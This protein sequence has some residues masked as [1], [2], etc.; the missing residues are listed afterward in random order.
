MAVIWDTS[1]TPITVAKLLTPPP[2]SPSR[3]ASFY[4]INISDLRRNDNLIIDYPDV[5]NTFFRQIPRLYKMTT[6]EIAVLQFLCCYI[7]QFLRFADEYG[8]YPLKRRCCITT[9]NK[10]IPKLVSKRKLDISL[11]YNLSNKLE[12]NTRRFVLGF[13][14]YRSIIRAIGSTPFNTNKGEEELGFNPTIIEDNGRHT[15][16]WRNSSLRDQS[17]QGLVIKD[18]WEYKERPKEGLLL[19]EAIEAGIKNIARYYYYETM[20]IGGEVD[21]VLDNVRKEL[22]NTVSMPPPKRLCL[23]SLVKKSIYKASSLYGILIGLL[24]GINDISIGNIMLNMAEDDGFLIDLNRENASG[25]PSKTG[26]KVFIVIGALYGDEDYNFIYDLEYRTEYKSWNYK[27]IRELA[28]VKAGKVLKQ[29]KFDK[30]VD[31]NFTAHCKVLIPYIRE[32]C[33]VVFLG[34]KRWIIKD[35]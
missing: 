5:F 28:E 26:I 3:T 35:W 32:L 13:T 18:L 8:F 1:I 22:N 11:A 4:F 14:L 30:E 12:E 31:N 16:I 2:F 23:D 20:H 10:P 29:E 27:G 9:L 7:N 33:K 15:Y 19:K 24:G 25:V 17:D 34:G 6:A 21:D